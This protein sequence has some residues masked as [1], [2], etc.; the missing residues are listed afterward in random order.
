MNQPRMS[1]DEYRKYVIPDRCGVSI[2]DLNRIG[3]DV[4]KCGCGDP[5]CDGWIL[6]DKEMVA[7]EMLEAREPTG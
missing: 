3:M 5:S 2:E 6:G 7:R 4:V 1:R